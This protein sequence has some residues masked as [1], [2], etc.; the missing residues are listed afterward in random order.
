MHAH[1]SIAAA[2]TPEKVTVDDLL[3]LQQVSD[4]R[5]HP[6]GITVA[7]TVGPNVSETGQQTMPS[8][9]WLGDVESGKCRQVSAGGT[10]AVHPRWSPDGSSLAFLARRQPGDPDVAS[11]EGAGG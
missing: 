11:A 10:R 2:P 9:V 6:T 4:A 5:L 1:D 7:Y 8:S 3:A